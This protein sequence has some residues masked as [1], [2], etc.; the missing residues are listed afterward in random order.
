[1]SDAEFVCNLHLSLAL[2][3]FPHFSRIPLHLSYCLLSSH[4]SFLSLCSFTLE[5]SHYPRSHFLSP[6]SPQSLQSRNFTGNPCRVSAHQKAVNMLLKLGYYSKSDFIK[7]S[8]VIHNLKPQNYETIPNG[9]MCVL[10]NHC[11][12]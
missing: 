3:P 6:N 1:M 4:F 10:T 9:W 11:L 8:L 12:F 5:Q 2:I 7:S